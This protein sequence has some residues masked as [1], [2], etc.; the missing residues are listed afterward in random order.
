MLAANSREQRGA[1]VVILHVLRINM[2]N[3]KS[4][5]KELLI[6]KV[7]AN[8]DTKNNLQLRDSWNDSFAHVL[9]QRIHS[10]H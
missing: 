2:V 6:K 10:I 4:G 1:A 3:Y 9:A 5:I 7:C 8:A